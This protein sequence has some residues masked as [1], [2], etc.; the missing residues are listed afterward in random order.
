LE[1]VG[2]VPKNGMENQWS[3]VQ[4][5][6]SPDVRHPLNPGAPASRLML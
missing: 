3:H 2:A 1:L 5:G 6:F 4:R